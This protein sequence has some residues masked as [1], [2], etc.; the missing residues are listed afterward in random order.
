MAS[1]RFYT[2]VYLGSEL[3]EKEF[4]PLAARAAEILDS[5]VRRYG[6]TVTGTDSRE[7]AVCA[8]AE[9]LRHYKKRDGLAQTSVG[10]V[11]VRYADGSGR[12]LL[13]RL[14]D[15]AAIYVDFHRGVA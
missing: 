8:M 5:F 14:Y 15:R 6:G 4:S 12:E 3:G 7:L 1:Y 9:V 13:R 10:G 2:D 11:S